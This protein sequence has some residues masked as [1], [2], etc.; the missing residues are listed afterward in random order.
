MR[1]LTPENRQKRDK[2]AGEIAKELWLQQNSDNGD[3]AEMA[4]AEMTMPDDWS[5]HALELLDEA[6]TIMD[7][8][9]TLC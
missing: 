5:N 8:D 3:W 4:W 2:R 9:K 6:Y 1:H 7:E